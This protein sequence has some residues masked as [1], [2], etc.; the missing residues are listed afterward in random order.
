M[1]SE[2]LNHNLTIDFAENRLE[3]NFKEEKTRHNEQ[4]R[5]NGMEIEEKKPSFTRFLVLMQVRN[6]FFFFLLCSA[7][8]AFFTIVVCY[9]VA[10]CSTTFVASS[11]C[12]E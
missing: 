8:A 4:E 2:L 3:H 1:E 10:H 7:S 11:R 12:S 9:P 5:D 6:Y